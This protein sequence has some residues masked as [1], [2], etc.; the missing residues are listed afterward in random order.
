V[1]LPRLYGV[2]ASGFLTDLVPL[3][4]LFAFGAAL[5]DVWRWRWPIVIAVAVLVT[6][7]VMQWAVYRLNM[8][9]ADLARA[10]EPFLAAALIG[11]AIRPT[12]RLFAR[13]EARPIEAVIACNALNIADALLTAVGVHGGLAVETNP[14]V[15]M[16]GLPTKIVL[17]AVVSVALLRTRPRALIWPCAA[18]AAVVLWHVCGF[19]AQT[20]VAWWT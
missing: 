3:A 1:E 7:N 20:P 6:N 11:A 18:L 16:I 8:P 14:I 10:V 9:A 17:V 2:P 12:T 4:A 5:D 13:L 15:N 19:L